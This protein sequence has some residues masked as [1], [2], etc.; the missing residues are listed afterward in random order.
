MEGATRLVAF[1]F[2][3]FLATFF[4]T[5]LVAF[6]FAAFFFAM[7]V[8][9]RLPRL[10]SLEVTTTT[11]EAAYGRP[12]PVGACELSA[13]SLRCLEDCSLPRRAAGY[14]RRDNVILNSD[15]IDMGQPYSAGSL[16]STVDDLYKWDQALEARKLLSA[17]SYEKWW[18]PYKDN[19]AYGWAIGAGARQ[20]QSHGG[21]IP[22]FSTDIARFPEQKATVVVLANLASAGASR[23]G[24]DLAAIL[25]GDPYEIP[26]ER[27]VAKVDPK[28]YDAY[29]GN[30]QLRP[31]FVIAVTREGD[32]LMTQATNQPKFEVFPESETKFFLRVVDAQLTFV[33]DAATGKVTHIILHQG[34]GN[35]RANRID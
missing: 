17:K 16:Y 9:F 29:V 25:F 3:A 11:R 8:P 21:G 32:K 19:Y 33:K 27:V 2:A 6:F 13:Q 5:F 15:Y 28:I 7:C 1:F 26:R 31:G 30:Y 34:G 10:R 24:R 23:I 20:S 14:T 12:L 18:T 35:Q 4:A 22:G